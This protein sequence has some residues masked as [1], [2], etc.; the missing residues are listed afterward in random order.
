MIGSTSREPLVCSIWNPLSRRFE[1]GGGLRPLFKSGHD[2]GA[3]LRLRVKRLAGPLSR[4]SAI[5]PSCNVP[6][7]GGAGGSDGGYVRDLLAEVGVSPRCL[8]RLGILSGGWAILRSIDGLDPGVGD[9]GLANT[10]SKRAFL[11]ATGHVCRVIAVTDRSCSESPK[12]VPG[13]WAEGIHD[14]ACSQITPDGA[15]GDD[16]I[17]LPPSLAFSINLGPYSKYVYLERHHYEAPYRSPALPPGGGLVGQEGGATYARGVEPFPRQHQMPP[18]V[19]R[20]ACVAR[21]KRPQWP[22]TVGGA[23]NRGTGSN[24]GGEGGTGGP[25]RVP[26]G[27]VK[28]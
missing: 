24:G 28:S 18:P 17:L 6:L 8:L 2:D 26:Q 13:A 12:V 23:P 5:A 21:V 4:E 3:P 20:R 9:G 16:D 14:N 1:E 7:T 15:V 27:T 25:G 19:A 11:A 10:E 22:P